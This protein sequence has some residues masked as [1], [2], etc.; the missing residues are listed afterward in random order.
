VSQDGQLLS[1]R[2]R[3][4]PANASGLDTHRDSITSRLDR[5]WTGTGEGSRGAPYEACPGLLHLLGTGLGQ[6]AYSN[7]YPSE[8]LVFSSGMHEVGR[9]LILMRLRASLAEIHLYVSIQCPRVTPCGPPRIGPA[10]PAPLWAWRP[11]WPTRCER[12]ISILGSVHVG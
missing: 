3:S 6:R 9:R 2:G 7:P 10:T 11:S 5:S 12:A 1:R 8:V 4:L